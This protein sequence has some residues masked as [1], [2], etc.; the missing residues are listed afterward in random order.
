MIVS[1]VRSQRHSDGKS[2]PQIMAGSAIDRFSTISSDRRLLL[3]IKLND[4]RPGEEG[5]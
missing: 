1:Q 3:L 4:R 2:S 5:R